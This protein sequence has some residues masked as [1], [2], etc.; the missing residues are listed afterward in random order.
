MGKHTRY[1]KLLELTKVGTGTEYIDDKQVKEGEVLVLNDIS[2]EDQ[3]TALDYVRIGKM[4]AE[5]YHAWEEQKNP[6]AAE[7][8]FSQE[9]HRLY[10]GEYFRCEISGGAASDKINV[11]L[12]GY[13]TSWKE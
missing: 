4:T 2:V 1:W 6:D 12:E 9:E 7:V 3:T 13:K 5:Y 11:Y 10:E 8:V